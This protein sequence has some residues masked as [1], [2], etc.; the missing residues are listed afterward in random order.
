MSNRFI[1]QVE[2]APAVTG[3]AIPEVTRFDVYLAGNHEAHTD[4]E[5]SGLWGQI[6][7]PRPLPFMS[8]IFKGSAGLN[9]LR[10]HSP[11]AYWYATGMLD[12]AELMDD[13]EYA[14]DCED[15]QKILRATVA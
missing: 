4:N 13:F 11:A 3:S 6:E 5:H 15:C 8:D 12:A 14:D 1:I 10:S 2:N 9:K 7:L